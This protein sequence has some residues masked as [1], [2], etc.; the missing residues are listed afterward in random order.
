MTTIVVAIALGVFI[1]LLVMELVKQGPQWVGN[2]LII[3]IALCLFGS[4][5]FD[6]TKPLL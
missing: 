2:V 6:L 5:A 3:T 1:A 4:M